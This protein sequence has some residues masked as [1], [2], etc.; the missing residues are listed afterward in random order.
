MV[1]KLTLDFQ[2]EL[3]RDRQIETYSH[4]AGRV[5][6]GGETERLTD[7]QPARERETDRDRDRREWGGK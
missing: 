4:T 5:G 7:R 6:G 1:G 3:E 2:R